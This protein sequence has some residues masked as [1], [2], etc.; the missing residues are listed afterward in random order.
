M[1]SSIEPNEAWKSKL[2]GK[3]E[4]MIEAMVEEADR[5]FKQ[6][7][8]LGHQ[9]EHYTE[10]AAIRA[11]AD[12]IFNE[13]LAQERQR[14]IEVACFLAE[15]QRM[16]ELLG[17]LY[18]IEGHVRRGRI[19]GS[20][21]GGDTAIYSTELHDGPHPPPAS[22]EQFEPDNEWK[23]ELQ[24]QI[25]YQ[26]LLCQAIPAARRTLIERF[27]TFRRRGD[28]DIAL[29][30][31]YYGNVSSLYENG[32]GRYKAA[33]DRERRRR[34]W[35]ASLGDNGEGT[36]CGA[37]G[38]GV[39]TKGGEGR[40][41]STQGLQ[42]SSISAPSPNTSLAP[43]DDVETT[44]R[45][46]RFQKRA[47]RPSKRHPIQVPSD[48]GDNDHV[49]RNLLEFTKTIQKELERQ[50]S[51]ENEWEGYDQIKENRRTHTL[52][53]RVPRRD[54][55]GSTPVGVE[56][57]KDG[58]YIDKDQANETARSDLP[59][60]STN[61]RWKPTRIQALA[62]VAKLETELEMEKVGRQRLQ[63]EG[64]AR[65]HELK[66]VRTAQGKSKREQAKEKHSISERTQQESIERQNAELQESLERERVERD[67][68]EKERVTA[69]REAE[70]NRLELRK[71]EAERIE[72]LERERER[73][74]LDDEM[75]EPEK[76]ESKRLEAEHLRQKQCEDEK[77]EQKRQEEERY[78]KE[79]IEQETLERI[80]IRREKM[81]K[82]RLEKETAEKAR[83]SGGTASRHG[84]Q[85]PTETP[86]QEDG[87]YSPVA[88]C[89][90]PR[91]F[92]SLAERH[93]G[94]SQQVW[95]EGNIAGV[96]AISSELPLRLRIKRPQSDVWSERRATVFS[97]QSTSSGE[98]APTPSMN[99]SP[100]GGCFDL[101]QHVFV[102]A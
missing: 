63:R 67:R 43:N 31:K 60:N 90:T 23:G 40:W 73:K 50:Q 82:E 2:K 36:A 94:L 54:P 10:L 32:E 96:Q 3:I 14:R 41:G 47:K 62:E 57:C 70:R 46:V 99:L 7:R 89:D 87:W 53:Y 20:I 44:T 28:S 11:T 88:P 76:L 86:Q 22:T 35:A 30:S 56:H 68:L 33:L 25:L 58:E 59:A 9:T 17:R 101:P 83:K 77:R 16:P 92:D 18:A 81:L 1:D 52:G 39:S 61:I 42:S 15:V 64:K 12:D 79:R 97:F 48:P 37:Q 80:R 13:Y 5:T 69:E 74:R 95:Y 27:Q 85:A 66:R 6:E 72:R 51:V 55:A 21:I 29:L 102:S 75:L 49:L 45:S 8:R 38:A 4:E 100:L 98:Q 93:S 26:S 71:V 84:Q 24:R 65:E 78:I 19:S 34:R 91:Q